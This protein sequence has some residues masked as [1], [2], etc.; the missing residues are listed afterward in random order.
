MSLLF[1]YAH[2][3]IRIAEWKCPLTIRKGFLI[4]ANRL[5]L[6]T[7]ADLSTRRRSSSHPLS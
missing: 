2:F 3:I 6:P 4:I 5:M 1:I 7:G